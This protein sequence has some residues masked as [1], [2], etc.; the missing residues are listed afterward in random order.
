MFCT[1]AWT[2]S[3]GCRFLQKFR[4][5]GLN[6]IAWNGTNWVLTGINITPTGASAGSSVVY[7]PNT[8]TWT[9]ANNASFST[10]GYSVAS[11]R[12]LPM[13]GTTYGGARGPVGPQGIG[14]IASY[15]RGSM[16]AGSPQATAGY[17]AAVGD[18]VAFDQINT[19]FGYDI[20]LDPSFGVLTL[21][22]SRTYALVASVPLWNS[23]GTAFA[24]FR[25]YD[26]TTVS[27]PIGSSQLS[28]NGVAGS[29]L[30]EATVTPSNIMSVCLKVE[31][32]SRFGNES[33]GAFGTNPNYTGVTNY[34]WFD[35]N[36]IGGL[37]PST[38]LVG[39]TGV[40]GAVGAQGNQ[41]TQGIQGVAGPLG[42]TG[43]TGYSFLN[44][45][46]FPTNSIGN[47]G[48]TYFDN[49]TNELYG[50]KSTTITYNTNTNNSYQWSSVVPFPGVWT[51]I[52]PLGSIS[53]SVYAVQ[54]STGGELGQ[55]FNG[56]YS[57]G[58]W[59]FTAQLI[60][61]AVAPWRGTACSLDGRYAYA[62]ANGN[63]NGALAIAYSNAVT[64]WAYSCNA[65]GNGYWSG[66]ACT[67]DG[68]TAIA[69]EIV[70]PGG[71]SGLLYQ[72]TNY[73]VDWIAYPG[74]PTG[75]WTS[76][77]SSYD[78]TVLY[79]AQLTSND[80]NAG[81]IYVS[82]DSEVELDTGGRD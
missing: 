61:P 76:V 23:V 68:A 62:V 55:I 47:I 19:S 37:V 42:P 27:T 26:I 49:D 2:A 59:V 3:H 35:I 25:W 32:I 56:V 8:I 64:G 81:W 77:A 43:L 52:A 20:T 40:T 60:T 46:G 18:I 14:A 38:N 82:T 57:N 70:R 48:D 74:S 33:V 45:S 72:S 53:A 1:A 4:S 41:G 67:A 75:S 7:S 36:V 12:A 11:R 9:T 39:A 65:A 34:P 30:A 51:A 16:S 10:V 44:A 63:G 28:S 54:S 6:G 13:V 69:A 79:A 50:P 71:A 31:Y 66:I 78:G 21:N 73:G 22:P 24:S 17:V 15:S 5:A 58:N 80:G 29:S